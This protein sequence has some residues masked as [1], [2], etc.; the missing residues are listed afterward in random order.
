MSSFFWNVR[1]FN[2]DSKHSVVRNWVLKEKLQFGCILETRVK[3]SK[4][5]SIVKSVFRDWSFISNYD[6]NRLGKIWVVW[7]PSVRLTPCFTSSQIITFSVQ[8][9]GKEDEFFCSFVYASNL[10][11]ERKLLWEDLRSHHDSPMFK[12]KPWMIYGDFNEI[13][14]GNEHSSFD[15]NPTIPMGMRD[16]QEVVQYCSLSDMKYHG[17]LFTWCNKRE[18]NEL[19]CKK[20]DRVLVNEKWIADYQ[21]CYGFLEAGGCSDHLRCRINL[22]AETHIV[23]K[24]F[25][26]TNVLAKDPGFLPLIKEYW[27]NTE[28]LF[29]ST[30]AIYRFSKKLKLLKPKIKTMGR[31]KL[32]DLTKKTREA[33]ETL[34]QRQLETLTNPSAQAM[35]NESAAYSRWLHV[36]DLEEKYLKQKSK[37]HWLKVGDGNNKAFHKAAKAREVRNTI[38]EIIRPDG[39]LAVTPTEIKKRG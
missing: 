24:P 29:H 1:G 4:A 36:S 17:P 15:I 16:F 18:G 21:Q 3:Q 35:N 9:E 39:T 31:D 30:S 20:L 14:K 26:F 32:G 5:E 25:K 13:L 10:V 38:K 37:L 12:D 8:M 11:E 2:K 7:S 34:C 27:D 33:F 19:I 28:T 23:R 22:G 6:S